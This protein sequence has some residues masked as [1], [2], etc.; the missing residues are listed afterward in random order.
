[1]AGESGRQID[2]QSGDLKS[3]RGELLEALKLTPK[4]PDIAAALQLL[5]KLMK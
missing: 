5:E 3:G 4:D 2:A 1:V